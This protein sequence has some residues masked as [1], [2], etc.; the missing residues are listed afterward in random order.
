MDKLSFFSQNTA[1]QVRQTHKYVSFH[2]SYWNIRQI[3]ELL[4]FHPLYWNPR[5]T[6]GQTFHSIPHIG[7][8]AIQTDKLRFI[9]SLIL[10]FT[11][12]RR[13]DISF[14]I[15][16]WNQRMTDGQTTSHFTTH[17][18]FCH[19]DGQTTIHFIPHIG[20]QVRQTDRQTTFHF[21]PHIVIQVRQTDELSFI[22]PLGF[23]GEQTQNLHYIWCLILESK[24][25]GQTDKLCFI[26]PLILI[27]TQ[28]KHTDKLRFISSL[29]YSP[30]K[31]THNILV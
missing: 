22:S 10:E 6:D 13:T 11:Y 7:I 16:Y 30:K 21:I 26:S 19:T 27:S 31:V 15:S 23:Q 28:D 24:Y 5:M 1:I 9:S 18:V 12:D 29:I 17:I 14:H 3:E 4:S 2:P 25:D 8:Y 20:I